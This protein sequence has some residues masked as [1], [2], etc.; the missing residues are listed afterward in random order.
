MIKAVLFDCFSVLIGDATKAAVDELWHVSPEKA[1]QFRA[2]TRAVDKGIISDE[3][4]T[5][6]Q[7]ELLGLTRA[8]FLALR[9]KGEVRNVEL[10]DYIKKSLK[11][12][13]KLAL[14]SNISSRARLDERFLPGELDEL[15]DSVIASGDIGAIKPQ[16][17]I[18]YLAAAR[19]GIEPSEGVML[20]DIEAFCTGARDVGMHAIHFKTTKQ[21]IADLTAFLDRGGESY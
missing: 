17:E 5:T 9:Q 12:N 21:G 3:E 10:I 6:T 15:F 11:G 18:Y 19:L 14:V 16:P 8:E 4:G 1:E 2:T 13:Y 7:A 20:D